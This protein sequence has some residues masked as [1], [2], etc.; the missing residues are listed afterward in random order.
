MNDAPSTTA[1]A[2]RNEHV[3]AGTLAVRPQ[4][5][6]EKRQ[7][8]QERELSDGCSSRLVSIDR[9]DG[10]SSHKG[11]YGVAR[12][13]SLEMSPAPLNNTNTLS[14]RPMTWQFDLFFFYRRLLMAI[15]AIYALVVTTEKS[16]NFW[17]SFRGTRHLDMAR[18]YL[19]I[20]V[21]RVGIA[22]MGPELV[23]L[24]LWC[25]LFGALLWAH[26][27]V[28]EVATWLKNLTT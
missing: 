9:S 6:T 17:R 2:K 14:E 25:L 12:G 26:Q 15:G 3:V 11:K 8:D 4:N 10:K 20:Q 28:P 5:R 13:F 21:L 27:Y 16:V 22:D 19:F 24:T 23:R 18:K 1:L 7:Q